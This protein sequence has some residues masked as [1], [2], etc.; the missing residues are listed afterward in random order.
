[1]IKSL[2]CKDDIRNKARENKSVQNRA[3]KK[4]AVGKNTKITC[5]QLRE[6]KGKLLST[7]TIFLILS[8]EI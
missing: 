2:D 6:G 3:E 8:L 5:G 1:M 4:R 7:S